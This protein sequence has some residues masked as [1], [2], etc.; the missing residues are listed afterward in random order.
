MNGL[1]GL[2]YTCLTNVFS[3]KGLDLLW[4]YLNFKLSQK[5]LMLWNAN[6][7]MLVLWA[8]RSHWKIHQAQTKMLPSTNAHVKISTKNPHGIGSA[9]C[10]SK[11]PW[12][13]S[14][15]TCFLIRLQEFV[16][17][18]KNQNRKPNFCFSSSVLYRVPVLADHFEAHQFSSCFAKFYRN[19]G[20]QKLAIEHFI[21][22]TV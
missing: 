9:S 22:H 15:A 8:I 10:L 14:F 3:P 2:A 1:W 13:L 6:D 4:S 12:Y 16:F 19:E 5:M 21:H 17:F 7:L 11:M 18:G 20:L